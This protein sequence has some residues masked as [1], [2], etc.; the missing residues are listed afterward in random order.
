[1]G[2]LGDRAKFESPLVRRPHPCGQQEPC[3]KPHASR[4][5]KRAVPLKLSSDAVLVSA[6][7]RIHAAVGKRDFMLLQLWA[8]A[9]Q[10]VTVLALKRR[11]QRPG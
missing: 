10:P 6:L 8:Q 11:W 7:A 9:V 4:S 5:R 3:R 1:M 2:L